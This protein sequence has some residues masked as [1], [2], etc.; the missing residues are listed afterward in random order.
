[1]P[2]KKAKKTDVSKI[3]IWL[4]NSVQTRADE[5]KPLWSTDNKDIICKWNTYKE[6]DNSDNPITT[7][8][9]FIKFKNGR[10]T[11]QRLKR[12]FY[13]D[14]L[15]SQKELKNLCIY[16]NGLDPA[17]VKAGI[18]Y[19]YKTSFVS[20][21]DIFKFW[22]QI[23]SE[24][25]NQD[26]KDINNRYQNMIRYGLE[27]FQ[28]QTAKPN[29]WKALDKKWGIA[30]LNTDLNMKAKYRIFPEGE[31]RSKNTIVRVIW[32]MNKFMIYL[33]EKHPHK[34]PLIEFNPITKSQFAGH[35]KQRKTRNMVTK[36]CHIPDDKWAVIRDRLRIDPHLKILELCYEFGLRRSEALGLNVDK[37][38]FSDNLLIKDQLDKID[39]ENGNNLIMK[40]TKTGE[41]RR[42]PYQHSINSIPIAMIVEILDT[43]Q[44]K[45]PNQTTK[46]WREL[47]NDL[48]Y[49]YDI[50]DCR[51]S[52][53]RYVVSNHSLK[54]AMEYTGHKSIETLN[55]YL[56]SVDELS[57]V[58]FNRAT[59]ALVA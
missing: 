38:M 58:K 26:K 21:Q 46:R 56:Q 20:K 54:T 2:R 45:S 5:G 29:S 50:H 24:F 37:N 14:Y 33:N 49:D 44:I 25:V 1:M 48:G 16:L 35:L 15:Y 28:R 17:E 11:W 57:T 51:W 10:T 43:A 40:P 39:Y 32:M 12:E 31:L 19:E 55:G 23:R 53:C 22:Q 13:R 6:K 47:M 41:D 59:L 30:L 36:R 8:K 34:Y 18:K 7:I 42:I 52:Y 27:W 3:E 9:R 4:R